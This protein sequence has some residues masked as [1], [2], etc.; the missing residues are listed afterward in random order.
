FLRPPGS[1]RRDR[2]ATRGLL[3]EDE[4]HVA[5]SRIARSKSV[6]AQNRPPNR[7]R[8]EDCCSLQISR[9]AR[10]VPG[11]PLRLRE[12]VVREVGERLFPDLQPGQLLA[13]LALPKIPELLS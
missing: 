13:Q 3:G 2:R 12:R 4:P 7:E 10:P 5:A 1:A 9:P 6:C 11:L 8:P